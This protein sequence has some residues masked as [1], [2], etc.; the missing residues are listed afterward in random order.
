M[1]EPEQEDAAVILYS[2][3]STIM[4]KIPLFSEREAKEFLFEPKDL[5]DSGRKSTTLILAVVIFGKT[6]Y[7]KMW[8]IMWPYFARFGGGL[9]GRKGGRYSHNEEKASL[10][11][12]PVFGPSLGYGLSHSLRR[13]RARGHGAPAAMR[14]EHQGHHSP[15]NRAQNERKAWI[16][17]LLY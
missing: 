5:I 8:S 17:F 7:N 4:Q 9:F 3:K 13:L 16:A 14:K 11:R 6:F 12:K 10:W 15:R 1:Q 2:Q